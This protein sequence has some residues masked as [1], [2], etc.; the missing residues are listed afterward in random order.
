[1]WPRTARRSRSPHRGALVSRIPSLTRVVAAVFRRCDARPRP[2]RVSRVSDTGSSRSGFAFA[3]RDI[4]GG[5]AGAVAMVGGGAFDSAGTFAH[6]GGGFRCT[7][8]V[9]QGP[10]AGCQT[11]QGVRWH[12]DTALASTPFRCSTDAVK[13]G[14]AGA[15]TAVFRGTFFRAG[16]GNTPSFTANV[17]VAGHDIAPISTGCRTS[18]SRA[19]VARTRS[20]TSAADHRLIREGRRSI[21]PRERR[22]C[23]RARSAGTSSTI[24]R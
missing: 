24:A 15:D 2:R 11:G 17:I 14:T 18:G 5:P 1:M 20:S 13:T 8:S 22:P 6:G 3:A 12:T 16:D 7:E 4:R 19:W 10:L 23:A 21:S 9:G